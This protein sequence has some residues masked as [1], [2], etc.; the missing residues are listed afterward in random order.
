M[1]IKDLNGKKH[2]LLGRD[3]AI[4]CGIVSG[5]I[6]DSSGNIKAKSLENN[7]SDVIRYNKKDKT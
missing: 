4:R 7:V 6:V 3:I 1:L 2:V 5:Y